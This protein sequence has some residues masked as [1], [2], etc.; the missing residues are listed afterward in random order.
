M[1]ALISIFFSSWTFVGSIRA[2]A[3]PRPLVRTITE[4]RC[5]YGND[6]PH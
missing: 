6:R 5:L 4:I 3:P 1:L 2:F